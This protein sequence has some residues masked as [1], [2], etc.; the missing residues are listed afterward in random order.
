M[1]GRPAKGSRA[2]VRDGRAPVP[3]KEST[4]RAMSANRG[5][6]TAPEL[7]LRRELRRQGVRGYRVHRSEIPGRPDISFGPAKLAIFVNGCFWHHCPHCRPRLPK[8]HTEF[9]TA[10]FAA[11]RRRDAEKE[12]LL[13]KTGWE[14]LTLW[15]C[16][17]RADLRG[18]AGRIRTF[19]SKVSRHRE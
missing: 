18:S 10:K 6:D 11:N 5:K 3:E 16:E 4:S 15:E 7:T 12:I 19:L 1:I 14:V 2:Y 9:W 13:R 8:T 17:L